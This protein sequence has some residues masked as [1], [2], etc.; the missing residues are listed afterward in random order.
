MENMD[1]TV[2]CP[3]YN[4]EEYIEKLD[5]S[6]KE[7]KDVNIMKIKYVLTESKDKSEEIL[8]KIGADYSKIKK[9][10]FSHSL[11]R[12]NEALKA[13]TS[14]I[15][16]ITQDVIADNE[17][18]ISNLVKPIFSGQADACYSRQLC[19]NNTIEK[20]TREFNY[21]VKSF[22]VTKDDISKRGLKTFFFS[23]ASSA[24]RTDVFKTLNGYDNKKLPINED[25]YLAYKLIMNGYKIRYCANSVVHHSHV[26][27]LKEYY[28]RYKLTGMFF[29]QNSY[30]NKFGT[31]KAGG[32]MAK[33]ILKSAVKE[34]NWKVLAK[35]IPNMCARFIGMKVGELHG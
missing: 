33:Y 7:Q 8:K 3:V 30:I 11:S 2:I 27:S 15:V 19:D 1:V 12:E 14:V 6:L 24:V 21:G 34:G 32:G 9:E 23:D 28:D 31:T 10:E 25:M 5:T 35:F 26:F 13:R 22:T 18:W 17:F 20:Y 4:A 29:K 16:F